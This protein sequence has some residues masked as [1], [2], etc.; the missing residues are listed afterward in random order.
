[1]TA[2]F[3]GGVPR[4]GALMAVA[5]GA[6]CGGTAGGWGRGTDDGLWVRST[7]GAVEA[8]GDIREWAQGGG[9]RWLAGAYGSRA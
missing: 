1:V 3:W 5:A 4:V 9:T 2:R 7:A 6:R 8:C